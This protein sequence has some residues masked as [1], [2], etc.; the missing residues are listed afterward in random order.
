MNKYFDTF[1]DWWKNIDKT[2]FL[3]ISLLF[4]LGLF[5]SLV[6]TSIIASDKLNTNS[7]YF[8]L[9]HLIFVLIGIFL[10]L[11]L[12]LLDQKILIRLS[13][14]LFVITFISLFLVP[15]IGVE[16]KGSKR[17]LD[18]GSLPRFQ[19]IETL[20]PFFVIVISLIISLEKKKSL[21]KIS[22]EFSHISAN[23]N[24]T[25]ISTRL[26]TNIINNICLACHYFCFRNKFI[27]FHNFIISCG[28]INS[29]FSLF[30]A[31]V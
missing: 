13:V 20:K 23:Y 9:K 5:F 29:I 1:Y 22:P 31:K 19:P 28:F 30:G 2:I 12:S 24:F 4:S 7:Y 26:R 21:Y 27:T 18:I 11:F 14:V 15:L 6:S 8:F 17:W 16:V 25:L 3:I 10:I